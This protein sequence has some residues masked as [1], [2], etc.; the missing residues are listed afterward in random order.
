M[1]I[2]KTTAVERLDMMLAQA[3]TFAQRDLEGEAVARAK[4]VLAY[5]ELEQA[6]NPS[7]PELVDQLDMRR[8]LAEALI[9]RFGKSVRDRRGELKVDSEDAT[10]AKAWA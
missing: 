6:R 4:K 2:R 3:E 10:H 9:R 7:D 1:T 5:A 8:L